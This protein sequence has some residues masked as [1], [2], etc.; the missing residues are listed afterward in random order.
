MA[1]ELQRVVPW[2]RNLDE[3]RRMFTL[4]EEDLSKRIIS[5]GDG[6]ASFNAQMTTLGY[7][8]VSLDPIYQC[9]KESLG[10]RIRETKDEVLA[11]LRNNGEN[12]VWTTIKDIAELE[13]IRM[14]AMQTFLADYE[15]GKEQDR[16]VNHALPD[17]TPF[18][19]GEFGLGLSSHFLILYAKLGLEFHLQAI[20]EMLRI[21]REVRIFPL[22]D[23]DAKES[24]VLPG[25]IDFFSKEYLVSIE[26]VNY[27]FQRK[28]NRMMRINK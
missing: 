4:R 6:P 5:F 9:S 28:G 16:Y 19:D 13:N 18:Q 27:E 8:V 25:I 20:A 23:L 10:Q 2:G 14:E 17:Q 24:S 15:A 26:P 21:C 7:Q 3:Y 12:F 1:F 11:Q 22:L